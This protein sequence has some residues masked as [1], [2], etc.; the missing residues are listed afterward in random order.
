MRK[1]RRSIKQLTE[2]AGGASKIASELN[3]SPDAIYKWQES[4]VPDRH[5][6]ALIPMANSTPDEMLAANI[7]ARAKEAAE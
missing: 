2:A 7:A 6:P 3:L 4:G 1:R 5:W